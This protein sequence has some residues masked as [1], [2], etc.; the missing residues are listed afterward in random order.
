[1]PLYD[2]FRA[3]DTDT[4]LKRLA[5]DRGSPL[6]PSGGGPPVFPGVDAKGIDPGVVLGTLVAL[7]RDTEWTPATLDSRLI[8]P[9]P[10]P[11]TEDTWKETLSE[12]EGPWVEE[13]PDGIRD[14]FADLRAADLLGWC[15]R[16]ARLEDLEGSVPEELAGWLAVFVAFAEEARD[17]D[18]SLF[19][20]ISL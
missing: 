8:W 14:L 20:W 16:W 2:Y 1:M 5:V 6:Y 18:E 12:H 7:I 13:L 4:V 17:H 15:E 10:E 3:P 11:G 19:C 9:F